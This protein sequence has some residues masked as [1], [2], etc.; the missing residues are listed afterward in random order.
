MY[1][2]EIVSNL[3]ISQSAVSRHLKLMSAGGLL[4]VRKEDSMKYLSINEEALAALAE[5]LTS[6][7]S[8]S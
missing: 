7:R 6:F 5:S 8:K 4:N 3:D 2:Q 1:A